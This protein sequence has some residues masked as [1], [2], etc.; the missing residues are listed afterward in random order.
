MVSDL[1]TPILR[2]AEDK[3]EAG[4]EPETKANYD[5]IVVAGMHAAL[6]NGP[7]GLMGELAKSPDPITDAAK[8]AVSLVLILR[9]QAKGVMPLKAMVPAATSLMLKALDF[10][11]RSKI[12]EVGT[13]ELVRATHVMTD[14]LFARMGITKQGLARAAQKVHGL[15]QDPASMAAINLKAGITA[16]P[17]AATPTPMP[18]ANGTP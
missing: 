14:F 5:K 15:T 17:G 4:L 3:I 13:P 9:K 8:G 10:V 7:N 6:A 1:T 16:H 2:R 11:S 18:G 12:A